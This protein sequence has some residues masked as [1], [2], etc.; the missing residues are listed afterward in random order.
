M[1]IENC[2]NAKKSQSGLS[3]KPKLDN[4]RKLRATHFT[5]RDDELFKDIVKNA[6]GKL[7]V[8]MPAAMLCKIQRDTYRETCSVEKKCKTK[9]ACIVEADE[10]TRKRMEGSLHKHHEDQVAGKGMNALSH[11]TLVRKFIHMLEAMKIPNAK[12]A[13][14]NIGQSRENTGMAADRKSETKKEVIAEARNEG[15]TEEFGNR[16]TVSWIQRSSCT[17]RRYCEGWFRIFCSI[18]W[19][20]IISV[21]NDG[22]KSNGCHSKATRMCRTSGGP[23]QNGRCTINVKNSEVRMSRYSWKC[24]PKHNWPKSWSSMEDPVVLLER[25]LYG[26]SFDRTVTWKAIRESSFFV[27]GWEKVPN[28]ERFSYTEKGTNLVCVRGRLK[29]GWEETKHESNVV[30]TCERRW[31]GRTDN[32]PWTNLPVQLQNG[33]K[34]VTNVWSVWYLTFITLVNS[35]NGHVGNTA[36]HCRQGLIQDSDFAGDLED[37]KSTS[38]G[39]LCIFGSHTF[40]PIS[41]MCKKQT[42]VSHSST[43]AEIIS[44]DAGLRMDGIPALDL[45]DLVIEVFHSSPKQSNN[46]TDI[47]CEETRRI[48]PHQTSTPKTQTKVPTQHDNLDLSNV[49]C[50]VAREVFSIWRYCSFFWGRRSSD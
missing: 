5:D 41:W 37:S 24:L 25:N 1:E 45:L 12:A 35:N 7:E 9:Y 40:V 28:L 43:E 33:P 20:G 4:A 22:C 48:I 47:K 16:A 31:F 32:G 21:T 8:P 13:V 11:Y 36:Q 49:D 14:E 46:T 3:K 6:R 23:G 38:G 18:Y 42:S 15:K 39:L 29:I 19:A 44:L 27:Y 30:S 26:P 10:S 2:R 17:P 34:L 50:F